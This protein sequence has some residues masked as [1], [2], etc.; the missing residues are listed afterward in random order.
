[1]M[2]GADVSMAQLMAKSCP[3][4]LG[5]IVG[6]GVL[7]AIVYSDR[8]SPRFPR[9]PENLNLKGKGGAC[10]PFLPFVLACGQTVVVCD[11][12]RAP[13]STQFCRFAVEKS[14]R[15]AARG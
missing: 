1:M 11:T 7:V 9:N 14:W 8:V 2:E 4:T 10:A 15:L 5:N 12:T 3:A 6:G 13:L